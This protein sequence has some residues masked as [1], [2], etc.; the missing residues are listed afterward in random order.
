[1]I[2]NHN[3]VLPMGIFWNEARRLT[4]R[5]IKQDTTINVKETEIIVYR[6]LGWTW[7]IKDV[8]VSCSSVCVGA[9]WLLV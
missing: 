2:Q 6:C 3:I 5:I 4:Q 1:M 7:Q 8:A 9:M